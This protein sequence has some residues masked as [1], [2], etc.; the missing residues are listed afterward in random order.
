[1]LATAPRIIKILHIEDNYDHAYLFR[2]IL[3]DTWPE[4]DLHH[5]SN[6]LE[7]IKYLTSKNLDQPDLVI[8]DLKL[9]GMSGLDILNSIKI[10]SELRK[11]PVVILTTSNTEEDRQIAYSHYANSFLVKPVDPA[12]FRKLADELY[13]YWSQVNQTPHD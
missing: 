7:A 2:M 8:L 5:E 6:G 12:G 9:P 10:H 11:I 13:Y 3:E 4:V 1:M